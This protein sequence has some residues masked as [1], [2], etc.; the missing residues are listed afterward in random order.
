MRE[1]PNLSYIN[2]MSGGDKD[3]EEKLMGIIKIEYP[4]E[5]QTYLHN[6][7]AKKYK[8]SADNVHKL[9]HKISILG[10]EKSYGIAVTYEENL[11][12]GKEDGRKDFEAIL[13]TITDYL[14]TF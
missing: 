1:Q 13:D 3:F 12:N 8:D 11:L 4:K 14:E 6:I 7:E 10:L 2:Q 5:K 9:K